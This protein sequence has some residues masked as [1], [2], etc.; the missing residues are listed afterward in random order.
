[1]KK[2]RSDNEIADELLFM[3]EIQ[4]NRFFKNDRYADTISITAALI[5][6][7]FIESRKWCL[8]YCL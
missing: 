5:Y 1:M 6:Y 3:E 7:G 8:M 4:R 2:V